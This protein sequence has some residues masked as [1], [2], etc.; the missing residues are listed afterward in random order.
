MADPEFVRRHSTDATL[1]DGTRVRI[2]PIVP[3][4]KA[5]L[6]AGFERL[7]PESRYRRFMAQLD[8]LTDEQLA[9]L[10]EI[11]YDDHYALVALDLDHGE[12]LGVARYVRLPAEPEVA[13]AAVTVIDDYQGRG[14]GYLLLQA[15]GAAAL[16]HGVRRFRGY[17]LDGNRPLRDLIESLAGDA[18]HDSPGLLRV[19][20]DL[21]KRAETLR[22]SPLYELLRAAARGEGPTFLPPERLWLA[23]AEPGASAGA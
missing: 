11:D 13:E 9:Y 5:L 23:G 6:V 12:G 22:G 7:S 1:R 15:L 14:V 21:P 16:E 4:D 19:E 2:R 20:I 17:T 10:T 3:D 8:R 18:A